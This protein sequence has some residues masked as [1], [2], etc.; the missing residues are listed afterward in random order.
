MIHPQVWSC[1]DDLN[2]AGRKNQTAEA[3]FKLWCRTDDFIGT[4]FYFSTD[5]QV[6]VLAY[7]LPVFQTD[8]PFSYFRSDTQQLF[9][10]F[11]G[12]SH[13][14]SEEGRNV[15]VFTEKINLHQF[16]TEKRSERLKHHWL[17][18]ADANGNTHGLQLNEQTT[19]FSSF[20]KTLKPE[21]DRQTHRNPFLKSMPLLGLQISM[22][23]QW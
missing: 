12:L 6:F 23:V 17:I 8:K 9:F 14:Q 5:S 19:F 13:Q 22:L 4:K 11:F 18:I 21:I 16:D 3:D 10:F 1:C 20:L 7:I 15:F 2:W